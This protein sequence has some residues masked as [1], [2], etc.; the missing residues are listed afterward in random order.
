MTEILFGY[1]H[2]LLRAE[3]RT[4]DLHRHLAS[5]LILGLTGKLS[6]VVAGE[7]FSAEGLALASDAEHTVYGDAGDLLLYLFDATGPVSRRLSAGLLAGQLYAVLDGDT[8][9]RL[10]DAWTS[11]G[12]QLSAADMRLLSCC[13]LAGEAAGVDERIDAVLR[14]LE[15]CE[16]VPKNIM[17]QLCAQTHLS[18]SRLSHLFSEQMGIPLNRYLVLDKMK[19][20]YLHYQRTGSI[21][22]ASVSA[23]FDSPSHFAAVCKRMF[24]LSFSELIKS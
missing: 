6:C 16:T 5:H 9:R 17:E 24:G 14:F 1:D 22:K 10:R 18:Q 21:T 20:G 13:D 4:P 19:K 8:V 12:G 7:T 3:Y 2:I 15:R 11:C 23:G